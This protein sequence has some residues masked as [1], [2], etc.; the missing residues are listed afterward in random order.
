MV[1]KTKAIFSVFSRSLC[2]QKL[3]FPIFVK[4]F[5]EN[6]WI[7]NR[8]YRQLALEYKCRKPVTPSPEAKSYFCMCFFV[9]RAD[10]NGVS[11]TV[12]FLHFG[13]PRICIAKSAK[14]KKNTT[15]L[16]WDFFVLVGTCP[17]SPLVTKMVFFGVRSACM[18]LC[19]CL[20]NWVY[21][22]LSPCTPFLFLAD[23]GSKQNQ[24]GTVFWPSV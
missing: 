6:S 15:D 10:K 2:R 24:N 3:S 8:N 19:Q 22:F 7:F 4:L 23:W 1:P 16:Y 18:C 5:S 14:I 20:K 17:P 9:V 11:E 12:V 21:Y 13:V